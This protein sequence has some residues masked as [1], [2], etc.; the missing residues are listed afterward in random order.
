M[1]P[2][3]LATGDASAA[4]GQL[5]S[6]NAVL[7]LASHQW[8]VCFHHAAALPE[9]LAACSV[10]ALPR[11]TAACSDV[12]D[13][14]FVGSDIGRQVSLPNEVVSCAVASRICVSLEFKPGQE[15][16]VLRISYQ[17]K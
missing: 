8:P 11:P 1:K 6:V 9:L 2:K 7:G 12:V 16:W 13:C 5:V 14:S 4:G 17:N 15:F 3:Y 10:T